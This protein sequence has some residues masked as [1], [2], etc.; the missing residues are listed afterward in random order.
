M[1]RSALRGNVTH[2][3]VV[4]TVS[5]CAGPRTPPPPFAEFVVAAGDSSY[6]V[7]SDARGLRMRGAPIVLA[8]VDGR[9]RELYV[10]DEDRSY[11]NAWFVGQALYQR[12]LVTGD[13]SVIFRDSLVAALAARYGRAHPEARPL[14][15]DEEPAEE[16]A[17]SASAELSVLAVHGPYLSIEYHVDTSGAG[18]DVWHMTRH[19]VLDVRSNRRV[20]LSDLLGHSLATT[21][22]GRARR[23]YR[24]TVDSVLRDQRPLA[25]RAARSITRFRFDPMSFALAAPKGALMIAFSAPGQGSG[26]EGFVLPLRPIAV[27]EPEWWAEAREAL[28]TSVSDRE[29]RWERPGYRVRAAYD[30]IVLP[31]RLILEDSTGREFAI[32]GMTAPVHRIYWLDNPAFDDAQRTA[33][34]RAFDEA[35]SYDE[36]LRTASMPARGAAG[37]GPVAGDARSGRGRRA[38]AARPLQLAA[39]P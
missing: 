30:T 3:V 34:I 4:L 13:S 1:T 29:E 27:S 12:D 21:V 18:D 31:V 9:F 19:V 5:A 7:R 10:V 8:H 15:P 28:P 36:A 6:W 25:R 33:L 37:D 11:E 14:A 32:G 22:L 23:L 38:G 39:R 17:S 35:A 16:P 26:G 20:Q 24:E 2:A